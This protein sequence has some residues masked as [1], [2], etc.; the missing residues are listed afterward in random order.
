MFPRDLD[1]L[2]PLTSVT[3]PCIKTFLNEGLSKPKKE[4]IIS[5]LNQPLI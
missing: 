3:N 4:V 2:T 1:I 5:K